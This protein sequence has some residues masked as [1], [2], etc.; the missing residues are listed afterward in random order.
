MKPLIYLLALLFALQANA[1]APSYYRYE[2]NDS[3]PVYPFGIAQLDTSAKATF[4][5]IDA[6]AFAKYKKAY[7]PQFDKDSTLVVW[8]DTTFTVKTNS[9]SYTFK[10]RQKNGLFESTMYYYSG[11]LKPLNLFAMV[12]VSG[13]DPVAWL[14]LINKTTGKY[15]ILESNFDGAAQIPLVSPDGNTVLVWAGD[16]YEENG[17][18]FDL[19][20][21]NRGK[22]GIV[23]T[24]FWS[25][26]S[27]F[28]YVDEYDPMSIYWQNTNRDLWNVIEPV[29][30]DTV[31]WDNVPHPPFLVDEVVWVGNN[32]FAF[33]AFRKK[34]DEEK[35]EWSN[36]NV[37]YVLAT[38]KRK[39]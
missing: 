7:K 5:I 28:R 10:Y 19:Y 21:V 35:R 2:G 1:Q 13:S 12:G 11:Y 33:K 32:A 24:N 25:T 9:K 8:G 36:V 20:N 6:V 23:L 17:A 34:Y 4:K 38:I 15:Y 22:D 39:Q 14:T 30:P 3:I 37:T 18:T 27:D 29:L 26:S 16:G 31:V